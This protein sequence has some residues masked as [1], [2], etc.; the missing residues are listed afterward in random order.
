MIFEINS[1]FNPFSLSLSL[2]LP[3]ISDYAPSIFRNIREAFGIDS[4]DYLLSLTAEYI[5]QEIITPGKSGAFF[6]F[7]QDTRYMLKT[8]TKE[9]KVCVCVCVCV[10]LYLCVLMM[11]IVTF[12]L[13]LSLS[14]SLYSELPPPNLASVL[15]SCHE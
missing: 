6:Y 15:Q 5:L 11:N 3:L 13:P 10:C 14:L 1:N 7:T 12:S 2:S 8:I 4:A 9:E